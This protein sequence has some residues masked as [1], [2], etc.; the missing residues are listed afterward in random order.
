MYDEMDLYRQVNATHYTFFNSCLYCGCIA[1]KHDLAPPLKYAEFYL[2]TREEAD[3]YRIPACVE[4]FEFLRTEKSGLLAQRV[5]IVKSKL[6]KKYKKAIRVYEMWDLDEI[7]DLDYHLSNSIRAG[8]ALGKESYERFKFKGFDF[9]ADGERHTGFYIK[10]EIL[11]IFGE[12]FDNFRDALDYGSRAFRIPKAKL[13]EMFA[14]HNNCFDTAIKKF[15]E[16]MALKIYKKEL[17]E[18]CKFFADEHK[19]NI[20]FVMHAVEI[21]RSK[22]SNLTIDKA[23]IKLFED[24]FRE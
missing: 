7:S 24:R 20:K 18:K 11:T 19:Q 2:K 1:T 3:F 16:E 8:L 12:K 13:R 5:D 6:A 22:N 17:K 21:Y 4:C 15:Q 23:L 14:E 9:E 10:N